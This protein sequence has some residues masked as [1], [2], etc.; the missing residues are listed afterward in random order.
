MCL[1]FL[2]AAMQP[3][4]SRNKLT[5]FDEDEVDAPQSPAFNRSSLNMDGVAAQLFN[6]NNCVAAAFHSEQGL[7]HTQEDRCVLLPNLA[8]MRALEGYEMD[9]HSLEQLGQFSMACVFD[10]HS[11]WRTSQYL[12]QH[13]AGLLVTHERFLDSKQFEFSIIETCKLIDE[14]VTHHLLSAFTISTYY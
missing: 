11:G 9:P 8:K 4:L 1:N 3:R 5:L 10:G 7:R 12:S 14:Q 6:A 13:F 2:S